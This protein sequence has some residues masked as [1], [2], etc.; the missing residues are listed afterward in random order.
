MLQMAFNK[1]AICLLFAFESK[2][3]TDHGVCECCFSCL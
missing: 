1:D 2:K 3:Q